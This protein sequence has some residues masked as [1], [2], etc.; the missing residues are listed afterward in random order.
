MFKALVAAS[1]A[2]LFCCAAA[3][4]AEPV[5]PVVAPHAPAVAPLAFEIQP[6][7]DAAIDALTLSPS[8]IQPYLARPRFAASADDASHLTSP[9]A[10][11][12]IP[13][14]PAAHA[15]AVLVLLTVLA[16]RRLLR[17]I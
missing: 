8:E 13:L 10:Q 2:M 14:P 3:A 12:V 9:P 15:G 6:P 11:A 1:I 5:E 4:W 16:R 17:A 7:D